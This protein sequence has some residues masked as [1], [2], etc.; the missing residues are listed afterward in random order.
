MIDGKYFARA[1][2][3]LLGKRDARLRTVRIVFNAL[4]TVPGMLK[5]LG[6]NP[7]D[8]LYKWISDELSKNGIHKLEDLNNLIKALPD[9]LKHRNT[10]SKIVDYNTSLRIVAADISTSTKVVFPKMAAMYW[11][12]PGDINPACFARASASIPA[13]FQPFTVKGVSQI[14]EGSDKWEKLASYDG[15]LP[16]KVTFADGGILSNFPIDL[17][18]RPGVPRA[19]T[20]GA[21]L[22]SKQRSVKEINKIEQYAGG[23]FGSMRHN[24]DYDFI[25]KNPLYRHLITH[26]PTE[27]YHW[28]DFNMSPKDKLGLF[29]AGVLAGYEFLENFDWAQYKELRR[30]EMLV[31][32]D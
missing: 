6:L 5:K 26:I 3:R 30:A 4:F 9:G 25:Y 11:E 22:G 19:P 27:S 20:L 24:M 31:T 8:E 28:L 7:G 2:S 12:E 13:F 32:S 15:I 18:E 1:L 14:T 23:L 29:R 16:D 10:G 17:F 21:R